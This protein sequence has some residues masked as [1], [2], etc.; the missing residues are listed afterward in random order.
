M[1]HCWKP[2]RS[3]LFLPPFT[4]TCSLLLLNCGGSHSVRLF[5]LSLEWN[6]DREDSFW[7]AGESDFFLV[8]WF[9]VNWFSVNWFSVNLFS[10][11]W[12]S[13]NWFSVNWFSVNWFSINLFSVNWISVNW[14]SVNW[15][16]VNWFSVNWFSVK[17]QVTVCL[18]HSST[19][20]KML[21]LVLQRCINRYD[22]WLLILLSVQFILLLTTSYKYPLFR[23]LMSYE[24]M[25]FQLCIL[26]TV[27][28]HVEF[29]FYKWLT[30]NPLFLTPSGV[31]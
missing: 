18:K 24:V 23:W 1:W 26:K 17:H 28:M 15:F 19:L 14:F 16:S 20:N 9:S 30:V 31:R 5:S 11:N 10:V 2:S 25:K 4:A 6:I 13:V 3:M 12:F 7:I 21:G 27:R 8:N 22:Y 29:T